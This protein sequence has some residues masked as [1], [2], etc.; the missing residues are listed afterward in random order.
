MIPPEPFRREP[1]LNSMAFLRLKSTKKKRRK[2]PSSIV[3]EGLQTVLCLAMKHLRN[4]RH[5]IS[6]QKHCHQSLKHIGINMPLQSPPFWWIDDNTGFAQQ[7]D[8]MNM[9]KPHIY[10]ISTGS[11]QMCA[12]QI[13]ALDCT[14]H[15]LGS[16]LPLHFRD[17]PPKWG[18]RE[19]Q[20]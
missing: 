6:P 4:S 5:T 11:L 19:Q 15:I 13:S 12:I 20:R 3:F 8:K 2:T 16:M 1:P 9:V 7:G 18:K 14:T 17:Q 10:K